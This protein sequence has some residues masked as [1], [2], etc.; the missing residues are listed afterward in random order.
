M[1]NYR[2]YSIED[3]LLDDSFVHYCLE[4][5]Q[6]A[7]EQ[8]TSWL[9]ANPDQESKLKAARKL[10]FSLGI[11]ISAEEK[12]VEFNKLKTAIEAL[13]SSEASTLVNYQDPSKSP[14]KNPAKTF[15]LFRIA[16]SVAAACL[17]VFLGYWL[18]TTITPADQA[19][20]RL[21]YE[22]V[23]TGN[24]ER[25]SVELIDGST[26]LLNSNST[27][28][29]PIDY[30]RNR[31]DLQLEGEA[32]FEVAKNAG[33]PFLVKAAQTEV[34][35]LGTIF[36][37]RSYSFENFVQTSLLEGKV[38]VIQSNRPSSLHYLG[39]GMQSTYFANAD[40]SDL[41]S[42]NIATEEKWRNGELVFQNAS[43]SQIQQTLQYWFGMEVELQG[44]PAKPILF[45]G[46]FSN[47][48]LEDV[49]KA[50]AYVNNLSYTINDKQITIISK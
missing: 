18:N 19:N 10:L 2:N 7:V 40:T 8:W 35:A 12:I 11:R 13:R 31:R 4:T 46:K 44:K 36:K 38:S 47:K 23:R 21:A 30:N 28:K 32:L 25:K 49:M 39:P 17:L 27:I 3:L 9:I 37:V 26:V 16:A 43:F 14:A 45:N 48:S 1:N 22:I 42:F 41:T 5:E 20:Q 50:I 34:E 33:K 6:A 24:G 29:I 15:S